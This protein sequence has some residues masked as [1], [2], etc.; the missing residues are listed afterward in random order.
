MLKKNKKG[1]SLIEL[2]I[3]L[4]TVTGLL[5]VVFPKVK[6]SREVSRIKEDIS[7]A[8]NISNEA[9]IL[10]KQGAEIS[11]SSWNKASDIKVFSKDGTEKTLAECVPAN[12]KAKATVVKGCDFYMKFDEE[13][14]IVVAVKD[15]SRKTPDGEPK[16]T[17]I[18]VYPE[19]YADEPYKS[20]Y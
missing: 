15:I 2:L 17:Y 8:I 6:T 12:V 1:F 20:N 10:H 16:E 11:S 4:G 3:V 18:Q 5:L 7:T 13:G 9:V 19:V 14:N